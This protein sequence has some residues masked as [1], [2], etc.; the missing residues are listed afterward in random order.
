VV[1]V[2]LSW[3]G[4]SGPY[5]DFK[6]SDAV[7]RALAEAGDES[8]G[9]RRQVEPEHVAP[10]PQPDQDAADH[11]PERERQPGHGGP[12]AQGARSCPLLGVEMPDHGQG[13]GL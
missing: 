13:P 4:R 8:H 7:C 9:T 12:H 5:R 1:A 3:F 6:A 11:R 10:G 2:D